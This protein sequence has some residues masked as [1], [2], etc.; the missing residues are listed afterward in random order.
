[1]DEPVL[2]AGC[3][4]ADGILRCE[5]DRQSDD[6]ARHECGNGARRVHGA[7]GEPLQGPGHVCGLP[8]LPDVLPLEDHDDLH[9]WVHRPG[10]HE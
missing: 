4:F 5:Q 6:G 10:E 8:D 9:G 3:A 7:D 2:M 1:M